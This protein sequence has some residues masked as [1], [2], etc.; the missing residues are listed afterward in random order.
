LVLSLALYGCDATAPSEADSISHRQAQEQPVLLSE[1]TR[2]IQ[3]S[4]VTAL[5]SEDQIV[6]F[7]ATVSVEGEERIVVLTKTP[8]ETWNPGKRA[9]IPSKAGGV[10]VN[11]VVTGEIS[12]PIRSQGTG[13]MVGAQEFSRPVPTGVSTGVPHGL[14]GTIGAR[15]TDGESVFALSN[16]HVFASINSGNMGDPILQP[17]PVDGGTET[18]HTFGGLAD[19][20]AIDFSGECVNT[21]DAALA[22]TSLDQLTNETPD[23]GYGVP[24]SLTSQAETGMEVQKYGRTSGLTY[25]SVIAVNA[26]VEVGYGNAGIACFTDQII[27]TPGAFSEGGDSGSLVVTSSPSKKKDKRPVGLLFA[28]SPSIS[29]AND[30]KKV[31]S[32]FNVQVDGR[33]MKG[34][35]QSDAH[36]GGHEGDNDDSGHYD[37]S[38]QGRSEFG[39][40]VVNTIGQYVELEVCAYAS[41][42]AKTCGVSADSPVDGNIYNWAAEMGGNPCTSCQVTLNNDTQYIINS[43]NAINA[44]YIF[45]ELGSIDGDADLTVSGG[46]ESF[47]GASSQQYDIAVV[48][49]LI[50]AVSVAA[51]NWI[52]QSQE[53]TWNAD[54]Q[55]GGEGWTLPSFFPQNATIKI[56]DGPSETTITATGDQDDGSGSFFW[57][58]TQ[59]YT[60]IQI[61]VIDN[62]SGNSAVSTTFS[63]VGQSL[64]G[65][66]TG[67]SSLAMNVEGNWSASV[68]SGV[69]PYSYDWDYMWICNTQGVQVQVEEC[70]TWNQGGTGSS[71][72]KTVSSDFFDMKIR[73][74]ITDSDSP[75][76][77]DTDYLIVDIYD[78]SEL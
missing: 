9:L 44:V 62:G 18:A 58:P 66:I 21:I 19:F 56:V 72:S 69:P 16:N 47:S 10:P 55:G 27:I 22:E 29:V 23:S 13:A 17:G 48:T 6:G 45:R 2:H 52:G 3:D 7:A 78:P 51:P 30:I 36:G 39:L 43:A 28:G 1:T 41:A 4:L 67:P 71:W 75:A 40:E 11:V 31:L 73:L 77:Q 63:V 37:A 76:N 15:V 34:K 20:E 8:V 70:D 25:G 57:V 35:V 60:D 5:L 50:S 61:K 14:T 42:T 53:I 38:P 68:E 65:S 49:T 24:W 64:T 26:T 33:E 12:A 74:T 59:E 54:W 32:R 46:T